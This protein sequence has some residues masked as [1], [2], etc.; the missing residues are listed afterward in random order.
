MELLHIVSQQYLYIN[1]K[2]YPI[3]IFKFSIKNDFWTQTLAP[4]KNHVNI[5]QNQKSNATTQTPI[6]QTTFHWYTS[7]N[8]YLYFFK[9][10]VISTSI[11]HI[12]YTLKFKLFLPQ[13]SKFSKILPGILSLTYNEPKEPKRSQI[14][15]HLDYEIGVHILLEDPAF[16]WFDFAH[17]DLAGFFQKL[18]YRA[19]HLKSPKNHDMHDLCWW[20]MIADAKT[21]LHGFSNRDRK[22]CK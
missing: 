9:Y 13:N 18:P 8:K 4:P 2:N 14:N 3:S 7:F 20:G 1:K 16:R 22:H 11:P 10:R 15:P 21:L 12:F 6:Q 17:T 5:F 19:T